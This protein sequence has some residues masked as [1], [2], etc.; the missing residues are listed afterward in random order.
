MRQQIAQRLARQLDGDFLLVEARVRKNLAQRAFQLTH[1]GAHV[2]G[3]KEGDLFGHF[4]VLGAGLV[5]Q[6]RHAHFQL[7]RLD[8]HRQARVKARDQA[9]VDV[10]QALGIGVG[11]HHDVAL[12]GQQ[13]FKGVEELF[14]RTVF[15]GKELDVIDQQKI[16][17]VVAL[18]ELVKG[19]AL[20]GFNHIRNELFR[21]DVEN[22]GVRLVFEQLVAHSVHQVGLTQADAAVDEQRVVQVAGLSSPRASLPS[23]PCGWPCLPP[24]FRNVRAELRRLRKAGAQPLPSPR[25]QASA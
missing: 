18:F 22:L 2:L 10:G 19:A 6:N 1:V 20:V 21:V 15:V 9:L 11:R 12:F 7:G 3:H 5:D 4:G 14:L 25:S 13:R 8:R 16:E 17:R 23:A 24:A